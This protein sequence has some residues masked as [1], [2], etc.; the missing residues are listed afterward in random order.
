M[1]RR[2]QKAI[3]KDIHGRPIIEEKKKKRRV[4]PSFQKIRSLKV[5]SHLLV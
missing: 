1:F 2:K 5:L 3:K 4:K